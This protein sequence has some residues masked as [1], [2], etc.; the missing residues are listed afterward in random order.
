MTYCRVRSI[1][2]ELGTQTDG[3]K[4][5][6]VRVEVGSEGFLSFLSRSLKEQ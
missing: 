1:W 2:S 6:T 5:L 3:N 4:V